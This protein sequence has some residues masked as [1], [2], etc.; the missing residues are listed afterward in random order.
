VPE[1]CT[2]T[3]PEKN[4]KVI[5]SNTTENCVKTVHI[6]KASKNEKVIWEI[7]GESKTGVGP[8]LAAA[9]SNISVYVE[10]S[11]T[12][13]TNSGDHF[14]PDEDC[15]QTAKSA[16]NASSAMYGMVLDSGGCTD[17]E[18][19]NYDCNAI[20]DD[21]TC[22]PIITGCIDSSSANFNIEA[23]VDDGSCIDL[24]EGCLFQ[25]AT[26]YNPL[27]T[28]N[29]PAMCT[30]GTNSN[31]AVEGAFTVVSEL[32]CPLDLSVMDLDTTTNELFSL[33][34]FFPFGVTIQLGSTLSAY[35]IP[36]GGNVTVQGLTSSEITVPL[37]DSGLT[38]S[39]VWKLTGTDSNFYT[40][41]TNSQTGQGYGFGGGDTPSYN[42]PRVAWNDDGTFICSTLSTG[43]VS[44]GFTTL[45]ALGSSVGGS[46][47]VLAADEGSIGFG[48]YIWEVNGIYDGENHYRRYYSVEPNLLLFGQ[49]C[50]T[51]ES[52]DD[53]ANSNSD[54]QP[55]FRISNCI[56]D[57]ADNYFAPASINGDLLNDLLGQPGSADGL[58]AA[59]YN[60][61]GEYS[62]DGGDLTD[63][64]SWNR[65]Q[66]SYKKLC[67][68]PRID[69]QI[70]YLEK[71]IM[72]GSVNWYNKHITGGSDLCEDIALWTV[73]FIKYLVSRKGLNCI[74]NCNDLHTPNYIPKTC[75]DRWLNSGSKVWTYDN[76]AA[77]QGNGTYGI[78]DYVKFDTI[79]PWMGDAA[80]NTIWRV[81]TAC[82]SDCGN[83]YGRGFTNGNWEF[84]NDDVSF[85]E[86]TVNYLD[87]F[88]KFATRYCKS[89]SPCSFNVGNENS[90][91]VPTDSFL[92]STE[93]DGTLTVGGIIL[94]V[95]EDDFFIN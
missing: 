30:F 17:P 14:I 50:P 68:P 94:D 90:F 45:V 80:P 16:R 74:F 36:V 18:M 75:N 83:P 31:T 81:K 28:V 95:D 65:C 56:D 49:G 88:F 43:D 52:V 27:A 72:N 4:V 60:I 5:V 64:S 54:F 55:D 3:C 86:Y 53:N 1:L 12:N 78:G 93:D 82:M 37:A 77:Y 6:P 40:N 7:G 51:L 89:C 79:I 39:A 73:I 21:G 24:I 29:N 8:H 61:Q 48:V 62:L 47:A 22:I 13:C 41:F 10:N 15:H 67:L 38:P 85:S 87:N 76:D 11:K 70:N 9:G 23:N 26:N 34:V 42:N 20:F 84:C 44:N 66:N 71:C 25:N 32:A 91:E 58:P 33:L 92:Y 19:F 35:Q 63:P 59:T 46:T 57:T 2:Y 69:D